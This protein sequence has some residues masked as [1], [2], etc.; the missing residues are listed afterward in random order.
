MKPFRLLVNEY[1]AILITLE[2]RGV[3][4]FKFST[5]DA[6]GNEFEKRFKAL[7]KG[8]KLEFTFLSK[9]EAKKA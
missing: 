5:P 7:K 8:D 1:G 3:I 4:G 2:G 9:K 6:D